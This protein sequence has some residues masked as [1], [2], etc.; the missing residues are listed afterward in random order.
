MKAPK[1]IQFKKGCVL[2]I[3]HSLYKLGQSARDWNQQLKSMIL[4]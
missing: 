1:G 2:R 3:L 4:R